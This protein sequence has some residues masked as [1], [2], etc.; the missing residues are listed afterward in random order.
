MDTTRAL[1]WPAF[2]QRLEV[3]SGEVDELATALK[4][5]RELR[6]R[7]ILEAVDAGF[8]QRQVAGA[9]HV[10]PGHVHRVLAGDYAEAS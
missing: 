10:A 1:D 4:D 6:N 7:I 5:A 3:A 8:P 2:E 9:A